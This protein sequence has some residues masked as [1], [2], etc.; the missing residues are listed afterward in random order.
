MTVPTNN[1]VNYS[2]AISSQDRDEEMAQWLVALACKLE[3][4]NSIAETN[5]GGRNN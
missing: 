3:R 5:I 1:L 4:L 2:E